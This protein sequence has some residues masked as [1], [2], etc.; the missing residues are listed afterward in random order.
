ML[1]TTLELTASNAELRGA[2]LQYAAIPITYPEAAAF[3]FR[4]ETMRSLYRYGYE[5]A[6]ADRLWISSQ[7]AG[8]DRGSRDGAAARYSGQ[9]PVDDEITARFVSR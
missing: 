4:A 9:C 2:K 1:R 3:D 7:S 8:S 5:C 6:R